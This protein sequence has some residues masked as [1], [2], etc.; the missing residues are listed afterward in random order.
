MT[1]NDLEVWF[2]PSSV[3]SC[4]AAVGLCE[5][6][7]EQLNI[8]KHGLLYIICL[9]KSQNECISS[10]AGVTGSDFLLYNEDNQSNT[11]F[12]Y[13]EETESNATFE[14]NENFQDQELYHYGNCIDSELEIIAG[15]CSEQFQRDMMEI[16]EENWCDWERVIRAYN[17][18]SVCMEYLTTSGTG[19]FYPN[20]TIQKH[21]ISIHKHYFHSCSDPTPERQD[22]PTG[23][24]LTLTLIPVSLIPVL[25]FLVV[26]KSRIQE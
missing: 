14:D 24:V 19:C 15:F 22:V 12:E 7:K 4:C 26:R 2:D 11:T 25:L 1:L 21:F 23:L 3:T 17:D 20:P 9:F 10:I 16:G 18:M 8:D 5:S 6:T 13:T